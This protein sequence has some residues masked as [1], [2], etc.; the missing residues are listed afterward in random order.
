MNPERTD[1]PVLSLHRSHIIIN[2]SLQ[3]TYHYG[4]AVWSVAEEHTS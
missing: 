2:I 4:P 1:A 3:R